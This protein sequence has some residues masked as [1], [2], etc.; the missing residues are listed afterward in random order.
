MSYTIKFILINQIDKY[1]YFLN[2]NFKKDTKLLTKRF[3]YL[4]ENGVIVK[5]YSKVDPASYAMEILKD[6]G[7]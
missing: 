3:S 4:I 1:Y 6:I 2:Y 5:T 7:V